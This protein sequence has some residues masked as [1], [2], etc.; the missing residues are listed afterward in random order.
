MTPSGR[1]GFGTGRFSPPRC[2]FDVE[3]CRR[4]VQAA[5]EKG[6]RHVD[7]APTYGDGL[8]ELLVGE[9]LAARIESGVATR[10]DFTLCTKIGPGIDPRIE[11]L[12]TLARHAAASGNGFR[13]NPGAP[14]RSVATEQ[15]RASLRRLR[16]THVDTLYLHE[17]EATIDLRQLRERPGSLA[18]MFETLERC[19]QEGLCTRYGLAFSQDV[20]ELD[21][22]ARWLGDIVD[23]AEKVGGASHG[24]R[25]IQAPL[26]L[27]RT[28]A[29][30]PNDRDEHPGLLECVRQRGLTFV[31]SAA[32]NALYLPPRAAR[33][34]AK[35]FPDA[36]SPVELAVAFIRLVDGIDCALFGSRDASHVAATCDAFSR[37]APG[38]GTD[39]SVGNISP[40][41]GSAVRGRTPMPVTHARSDASALRVPV[42]VGELVDKITILELKR[43]HLDDGT[44]RA[45]VETE[46]AE[47]R[48]LERDL[49]TL[50]AAPVRRLRVELARTNAALWDIEDRLREH[51][52]QGDFGAVFVAAARSVY[53]LN[54]RRAAVKKTIDAATGS[55]LTEEK[56]YAR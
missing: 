16:T 50:S 19:R 29:L 48:R 39:A 24:L 45:N 23:L 34:L 31:A 9:A 3:R 47:L 2:E 36:R 17:P 54:D 52:R 18:T 43:A 7:C 20:Y 40:H 55:T 21:A 26:S 30:W 25:V 38:L 8:G 6:I 1:P 35:R 41:V 37:I 49:P 42:S 46:L 28:A 51:E 14:F 11:C 15:L 53:R 12:K 5:L 33:E 10:E 22:P 4:A 13:G 56:C 27:G 44:A 32:L